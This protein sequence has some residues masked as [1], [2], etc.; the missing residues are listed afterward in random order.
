MWNTNV[1][2]FPFV[3]EFITYMYLYFS[4]LCIEGQPFYKPSK[5]SDG[6]LNLPPFLVYAFGSA[7]ATSIALPH[8]IFGKFVFYFAYQVRQQQKKSAA[9][10]FPA[11]HLDK[12]IWSKLYLLKSLE[13]FEI[14]R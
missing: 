11:I 5:L 4:K 12:I 7:S 10:P 3:Y 1:S 14:R 2:D 6:I 8:L 9:H 13:S